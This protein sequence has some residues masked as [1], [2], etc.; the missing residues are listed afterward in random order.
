M[1]END[2]IS[3]ANRGKPNQQQNLQ[4]KKKRVPVK[5]PALW[6][7]SKD[8]DDDEV[9]ENQRVKSSDS[10]Y[11][12]I[13]LVEKVPFDASFSSSA[14]KKRRSKLASIE[15]KSEE[16]KA[17]SVASTR[18]MLAFCHE[19]TDAGVKTMEMLATQGMFWIKV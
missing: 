11:Y 18:R 13:P 6:D 12:E 1:T 2:Y 7:F 19:A 16:V 9:L 5:E 8:D 3:L 14:T 4:T 10:Y 17:S 15:A